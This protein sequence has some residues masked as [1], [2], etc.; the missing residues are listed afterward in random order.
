[1]LPLPV[2][3]VREAV[4]VAEPP[5]QMVA[6][7]TVSVGLAGMVNTK[8]PETMPQCDAAEGLKLYVTV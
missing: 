6:L 8:V 5:A 1:M 3:P 7:F 2:T 4:S